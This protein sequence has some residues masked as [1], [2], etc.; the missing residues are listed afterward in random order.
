MAFMTFPKNFTIPVVILA[1]LVLWVQRLRGVIFLL[2][3]G[4]SVAVSD[5]L[6]FWI[7][8]PLF[9]R[10]RPCVD[11]NHVISVVNCT[12][13]Y[14]FPSNH[15]INVFTVATLVSLHFK[16]TYL[17]AFTLAGLVGLSRIYLGVHYP[18]DILG[19]AILGIMI[20][21]GGSLLNGWMQ[22]QLN[23]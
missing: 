1:L 3:V 5:G 17:L 21:Y 23:V 7:L 15:A 9:A 16:N 6:S 8:K 22:K 10:P 13:G 19:G 2:A 4:A 11:L 14:S 12:R 20:G 18:S